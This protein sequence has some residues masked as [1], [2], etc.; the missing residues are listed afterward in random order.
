MLKKIGFAVMGFFGVIVGLFPLTYFIMDRKFG[1]LGGKSEALLS[2]VFWNIGFYTHII[3][4]GLA[5]LIGWIQFNRSWRAKHINT[6][7]LVG[8]IYTITALLSAAAGFQIGFNATGGVDTKLG[9]ILL[10]VIWFSTT[11]TAYLA[12]R[13]GNVRKHQTMMIYSYAACFSA[14]TLRI[15]LPILITLFKGDFGAA[16]QIVAWLAWVPNMIVAYLIV[17]KSILPT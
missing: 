13:N 5:L 14:V 15:W 10:G 6:H 9:F 16:Y 4:G 12:I 3:L 11:L 17:Q 8:K 2:D 1:L 7:R